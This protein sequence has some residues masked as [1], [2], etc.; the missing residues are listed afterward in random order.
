[1]RVH[2]HTHTRHLGRQSGSVIFNHT[3]T[4]KHAHTHTHTHTRTHAQSVGLGDYL[5]HCY[6]TLSGLV[7]FSSSVEDAEHIEPMCFW[8]GGEKFLTVWN[9]ASKVSQPVLGKLKAVLWHYNK[10]RLYALLLSWLLEPCLGQ[11]TWFL[12]RGGVKWLSSTWYGSVHFI[13]KLLCRQLQPDMFVLAKTS[14]CNCYS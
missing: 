9:Y 13:A 11:V 14:D 1:M 12:Y 8:W 3:H 6:I 4:H 10:L 2:A 5:C 7:V